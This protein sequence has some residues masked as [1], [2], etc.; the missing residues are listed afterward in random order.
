M[1]RQCAWC[2]Y[3]IDSAGERISP[4]RLPKLY[5]ATHGICSNCGVEWMEQV[6]ATDEAAGS[7]KCGDNGNFRV[8]S[9]VEQQAQQE[10]RRETITQLILQL[11][12]DAKNLPADPQSKPT[13]KTRSL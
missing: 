8:F 7:W 5:E 9:E 12:Q 3:L 4:T 10:E 11:Q 2:L 1:V 6:L 13:K